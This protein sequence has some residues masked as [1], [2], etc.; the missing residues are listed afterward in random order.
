MWS[1]EVDVKSSSWYY[2]RVIRSKL[3]PTDPALIFLIPLNIFAITIKVLIVVALWTPELIQFSARG[4][5]SFLGGTGFCSRNIV[6]LRAKSPQL[7]FN[8]IKR[9]IK[10]EKK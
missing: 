8:F 6:P 4:F 3:M 9:K 5:F 1:N 7:S 10:K 2:V